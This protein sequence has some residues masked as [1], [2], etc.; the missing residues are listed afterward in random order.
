[1][2][3]CYIETGKC[4]VKC[5]RDAVAEAM[6]EARE[7]GWCVE[8]EDGADM[9]TTSAE[10][11]LEGISG[12]KVESSTKNESVG[13]A[14]EDHV[15][16][17][18]HYRHSKAT[19]DTDGD[20]SIGKSGHPYMLT[21]YVKV[22]TGPAEWQTH[23]Q[24]NNRQNNSKASTRSPHHDL[25][26]RLGYQDTSVSQ[27]VSNGHVTIKSH[28]QQDGWVQKKAKVKKGQLSEE[29]RKCDFLSF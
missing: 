10:G 24:K 12:W 18:S 29:A 3:N 23:H 11:F 21:I 4:D 2:W 6:S 15:W 13:D 22:D 5:V 25:N 17:N 20:V 7:H 8:H 19:P 26:N 27:R 1:M 16:D 28:A 9:R 14:S